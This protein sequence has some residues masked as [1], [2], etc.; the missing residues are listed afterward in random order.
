LKVSDYI[1]SFLEEKGITVVFGY[2]GGMITHLVDSIGKSSKIRFIQVYHEQTGAIAAEGYARESKNVGVAISTSGPGATNMITGIADA[3]F[4]SIPVIY[5]TGQVNTYECKFDKPIRQ[6]GFQET[7]IVTMV[8]SITKYST[9]IIDENNIRYELEKALFYATDGRKGPVLLDIPMNVQR[10]E[11]ECTTLRSF[12]QKHKKRQ[13][14]PMDEIISALENAKRP[15]IVVGGGLANSNNLSKLHLLLQKTELPIV[16]SLM[17]KGLVSDDY[18]LH[19][20]MIGSYGNRCANIAMGNADLIISLASRLDTRQT[21]TLLEEFSK[22]KQ[23]I[24]VDIDNNELEYHRLN[25][26]IKVNAD[27]GVFLTEFTNSNIKLSVDID[28]WTNHVLTLKE[29]FN[30]K[31]EI[32]NF[33]SNRLPY[34]FIELLNLYSK[35]NEIICADIGQNQMWAAQMLKMKKN[36][37]FYT[38]GGLAPMGYSLPIAIGA[39]F[40]NPDT[41]IYSING[42]GGFHMALQSLMLISQYNL[43]IKVIVI[44]NNALGMITQFQDLYFGGRKVGTTLDGGYKVPNIE[45]IANAY[46]LQ[47]FKL[48]SENINDSLEK[49]FASRNCIIECVV[50]GN[51]QVSPKLE[52]NNSIENVSPYLDKDVLIQY[53][54]K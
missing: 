16:T 12:K 37:R 27:V 11:V 52:F 50:D 47:Y 3:F 15:L 43:P 13:P 33:V 41:N 34:T 7:D 20:G 29:K 17:G 2:I 22:S 42:D 24:Q 26:R 35:E 46:N 28:K 19:L 6:Q 36:Q 9:L 25:N 14:I 21:G 45:N 23:I 39:S 32:E 8:K 10:A 51:T 49:I 30:Q 44:N 5:I 53:M 1:V 4:D 40:A 31:A 18:F 38:S 48:D 54:L